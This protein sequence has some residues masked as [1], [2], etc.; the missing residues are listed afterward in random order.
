M[1]S[2]D[3]N[4]GSSPFKCAEGALLKI[5]R[6]TK[7]LHNLLTLDVLF[8]DE[9]GQISAMLI[10]T[11]DIILRKLRNSDL[12]FGG[13]Y[14]S[15]T[16]DNSQIQPI[17]Q[18][19]FLTSTLVLTCFLA[20]ELKHSVRAH[21]DINFQ[22]LQG[23]TRMDPFDLEHDIETKNDFFNLTE[24]IL[25]FV[26]DWSDER[27]NPN[28]MRVFSRR[29]PAQNALDKYWESIKRQLDNKSI[30]Y[31]ISKSRDTQRTRN[32]SGEYTEASENSIKALNKEV[33]EPTE[34]VFFSGGIYECTI[35]DN[36]ERY[37][38]S[39]LAFML[40]LPSQK[41]IDHY[42]GILLWLPPAGTQII[43]YNQ[44]DLPNRQELID[45]GWKE[46]TIGVA[47]ERNVLV[48][49]GLHAK[50][51]MYSLKHIGA[52]T[53]NKS[54]GETLPLG[55]A[56]EIT[57]KYSPWEKGQIVVVLS[58]TNKASSTIIVGDKH[59]AIQK[60]VGDN[61]KRNSMDKIHKECLKNDNY[62]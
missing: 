29:K 43:N 39:Q 47:P 24:R 4:L 53:I 13:V 55:L 3:D 33:K 20:L 18:I 7:I 16:M 41:T 50:R 10:C 42:D 12:P 21:N 25:T 60:N 11:I 30:E 57:E 6:N 56:V 8:I 46:V 44:N 14:I 2:T 45:L 15:G 23:I 17:N 19:P 36:R 59:Y 9:M 27:I 34:I 22:R 1:I 32:S 37:N 61:N 28:M 52:I 62:Q 48:Q 40:D 35:N 31:R 26:P 38:Q 58:R 5:R 49:G 51:L 54:Q